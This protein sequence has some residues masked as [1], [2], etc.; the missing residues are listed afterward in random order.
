MARRLV[1]AVAVCGTLFG[2]MIVAGCGGGG[3]D[4]PGPPP[5][6]SSSIKGSV[7]DGAGGNYEV[8][9]D[10]QPVPG[11]MQADDTFEINGV[12]PGE[13]RVAVVET[14]GMA[15]GYVTV[16]VEVGEDVEIPPIVP[17][18]GGQIV[19]IVTV[20][21][22]DGLRPLA[23][24][25]VTA[26]PAIVIRAAQ[27]EDGEPDIWPPPDLPSFS[28]FTEDD[29]AYRIRA[30]PEGEYIVTVAAPEYAEN[31]Q[32]VW[33][34]AARTAVADFELRP[35]IDPGVGTVRGCV[36][37]E[38]SNGLEPIEGAVV[39]IWSDDIWRPSVFVPG[40][41]DVVSY[42]GGEENEGSNGGE[43]DEGEPGDGFPEPPLTDDIPPPWF[44]DVTTLT[45]SQGHYSLNAPAGYASID[46]FA[47]GYEPMWE[48]IVIQADEVLERNFTLEP[49]DEEWPPPPGPE[50]IPGQE[51][52]PDLPPSAPAL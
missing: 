20:R 30:V 15:G 23:G 2:L 38:T 42:E 46:V 21:D 4:Q 13:H 48:E 47:P 36:M 6:Q 7:D 39:C 52:R 10:G 34:Q 17:E 9:L 41:D 26:Q 45:D 35:A 29:G 12:P 14:G 22:D 28:T 18:L 31:Y 49:W 1:V 51:P 32:W 50:P 44:N 8:L 19:G 24:V 40:G 27:G 33:V 5:V 3:G 37:G 11:A 43:G 16:A 25:E